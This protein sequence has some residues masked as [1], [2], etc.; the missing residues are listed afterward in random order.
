MIRVWLGIWLRRAF[1]L[2]PLPREFA[3]LCE[4]LDA[5]GRA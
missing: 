1:P 2:H 5:A 3:L 4:A